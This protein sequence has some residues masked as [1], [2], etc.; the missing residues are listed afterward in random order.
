VCH[1]FDIPLSYILSRKGRDAFLNKSE[2]LKSNV[3]TKS[4]PLPRRERIKVRVNP[5][6]FPSLRMSAATAAR[7]IEAISH[8]TEAKCGSLS[9]KMCYPP[10][11]R[12][13]LFVILASADAIGTESGNLPPAGAFPDVI[14]SVS[15]QRTEAISPNPEKRH[16]SLLLMDMPRAW[17]CVTSSRPLRE[18]NC[19]KNIKSKDQL[20]DKFGSS[21]QHHV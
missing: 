3:S 15:P 18:S 6:G 7:S 13:A 21:R 17:V 19:V 8:Q 2:Y 1:E 12:P 14:A 4:S 11:D 20:I 10:T 5:K 9:S 16:G